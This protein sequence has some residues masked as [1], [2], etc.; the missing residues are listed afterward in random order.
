VDI[1]FV[2]PGTPTPTATSTST[3][4]PT[5]EEPPSATPITPTPSATPSGPFIIVLPSCG[6]PNTNGQV[7]ITVAGYNW[8]DNK[9]IVLYWNTTGNIRGT[10]PRGHGGSFTIS[11]LENE[12][13]MPADP[14]TPNTYNVLAYT[15]NRNAIT[16]YRVP[17]DSATAVPTST[18]TVTPTPDPADLIIVG[19]PQLISQP[20]I[21]AY[22]PVQ[23]SVVIS[24]TGDVDVNNQFFVDL[25]LDPQGPVQPGD[26][27]IPI[28][29]SSGYAGVSSLPGN[30][31]RVISIT[32]PFG[33]A[34]D[35]TLHNVYGM[36]DSIEQIDESIET[37]NISA[38]ATADYVTPGPT[39]TATATPIGGTG[40]NTLVG[41]VYW[42][43]DDGLDPLHR[44]TV[45][46]YNSLGV[47]INF[48][49]TDGSGFYTFP[50]LPD[51][52]YSVIACGNLD[53]DRSGMR[54]S[55][56]IPNPLPVANIFTNLA[57]CP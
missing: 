47:L 11:W 44:A 21:I 34:N 57:P 55:I 12:V 33:F 40:V 48:A 39:P 38:M 8:P 46:L 51:D 36:V 18:A 53:G 4:T 32:A 20:P 50:N 24:N 37:N 23:F 17:C 52:T 28:N 35:P 16:H 6:S 43:S 45:R 2:L 19:P 10:I 42:T 15:D 14:R 56:L 3:I 31:T 26:I 29:Q 13:T 54:T 22:R 5:P 1:T 41:I 30:A 25:F 49:V 9:D 27:R 7:R